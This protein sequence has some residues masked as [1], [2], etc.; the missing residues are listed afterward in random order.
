MRS[1]IALMLRE[2]STRYGKTPGGYIWAIVEPLAAIA[3]MSVAFSILLRSPSLG[4]SFIL[5]YASGF[6]P[7]N[8]YQAVSVMTARSIVFSKPLLQYPSVTWVDAILARFLLNTLTS[9]L[10]AFL[11][12][13]II[14]S[15]T[16]TSVVLQAGPI[17]EAMI[18]GAVLG[19]GVGTL[20]CLI[21]G[22]IPTWDIIWSL[23]TRPL[24]I[25]SGVIF[26]YEDLPRVVQNILWYNPLF[27]ITGLM[28]MG[29]YPMYSPQ[30]ISIPYILTCALVPLFFGLLF[31]RRY[32]RDILNG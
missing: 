6:L 31:L 23:I 17:M 2:M 8:I 24:F 32:Y 22:L 12:M 11:V 5:F 21:M 16:D 9:Y 26:I 1:V 27:H 13:S 20:N 7:F 30:Y 19:L 25:V 3:I 18:L 10:V 4:N 28:R 15:L 14:I 29:V